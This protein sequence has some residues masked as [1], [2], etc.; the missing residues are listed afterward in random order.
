MKIRV[1]TT[2]NKIVLVTVCKITTSYR[3][4]TIAY[5]K[6]GKMFIAFNQFNSQCNNNVKELLFKVV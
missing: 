4:D 3:G 1:L 2:D 5:N 6:A